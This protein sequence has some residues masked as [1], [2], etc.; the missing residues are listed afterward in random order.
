VTLAAT[1][2]TGLDPGVLASFVRAVSVGLDGK[3]DVFLLPGTY[4]VLTIPQSPLEPSRQSD[5]AL[6]ANLPEEWLVPSM[7]SEQAGKVIVLRN[8]PTI[9]GQVVDASGKP[10]IGAQ[11]QAVASP[12][13]IQSDILQDFLGSSFVPRAS[14]GRVLD[15]GNFSF[16]TDPG[17][18]DI[19][20]RPGPDTG[21]AWL[22][23]PGV[24]VTSDGIGL[25]RLSVPLPFP[26]RGTVTV[27]GAEGPKSIPGALVRAYLY[28]KNGQYTTN[29]V[30]ADSVV[31]VAET[32]AN[33]DGVFEVSIPAELNHRE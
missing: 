1:K 28:L 2:I 27:D 3:F 13:S 10:V 17:T 11:V 15:G 22:V 16:K 20:V 26:Y 14:A 23:M 19:S 24:P 18:F 29:A 7:P 33:R 21:F 32:R 5:V 12:R 31:Q 4:R 6:A 30:D 8:A 25:E 9:L